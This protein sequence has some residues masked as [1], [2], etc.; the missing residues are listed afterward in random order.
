MYKRMLFLALLII[1]AAQCLRSMCIPSHIQ[2]CVAHS[3]MFFMCQCLQ[4]AFGT[5]PCVEVQD[6]CHCQ[7]DDF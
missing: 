3:C 2:S 1:Y 7:T 6:K 4:L 5:A